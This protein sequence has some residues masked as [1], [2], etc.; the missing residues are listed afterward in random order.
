MSERRTYPHCDPRVLHSPGECVFCDDHAAD[1]Q[2]E[3][4]AKGINFTGHFDEDKE[5]CPAWVA[6]GAGS[7]VWGGNIPKTQVDLDRADME[8][9]SEIIAAEIDIE[10]NDKAFEVDILTGKITDG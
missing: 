2:A 7:Q 6:R 8:M 3:R 5:P 10:Y 1:L 9:E 4:I